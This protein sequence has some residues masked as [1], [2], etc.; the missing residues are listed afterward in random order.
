MNEII[1]VNHIRNMAY[2]FLLEENIS[3]LP[4]SSTQILINRRYYLRYYADIK[5][6]DSG[7]L[8]DVY[9]N[10]YVKH[11]APPYDYIIVV[12][13][14]CNARKRNWSIMHKL[15]CIELGLVD[16]SSIGIGDIGWDPV[17]K[18]ATQEAELFTLFATC[19]DIVLKTL[20]IST[21]DDI[22][23]SCSIP[24]QKAIVKSKYF[25]GFDFSSFAP[26]KTPTEQKLLHNFD[27]YI[28]EYNKRK[29]LKWE[30]AS[31]FI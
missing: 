25:S 1:D 18:V 20:G 15:A 28:S 22:I 8:I 4:I 2:R 10:S 29:Y 27:K 3:R 23:T 17:T 13:R 19:P 12:N 5:G 7:K 9:G 11:M 6:I 31:E 24:Y 30:F 16:S 14:A 26:L 21:P